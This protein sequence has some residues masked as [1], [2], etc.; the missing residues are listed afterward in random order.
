[1]QSKR[2]TPDFYY[3]SRIERVLYGKEGSFRRR[4]NTNNTLQLA[5]ENFSI[6][7]L[8]KVS[9]NDLHQE[10]QR[11]EHSGNLMLAD[12]FFNYTLINQQIPS[13]IRAK[14]LEEIDYKQI[15]EEDEYKRSN[16]LEDIFLENMNKR[17]DTYNF[18]TPRVVEK[19][20]FPLAIFAPPKLE[21]MYM[22]RRIKELNQIRKDRK[23][24]KWDKIQTFM[25]SIGY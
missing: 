11:L 10:F 15:D 6:Y 7:N 4:Y 21:D 9:V 24:E 13:T 23:K 8:A 1:M 2:V 16:L 20:H 22:R 3:F 25:E 14:F 19:K 18:W 17:K 5:K 12:V